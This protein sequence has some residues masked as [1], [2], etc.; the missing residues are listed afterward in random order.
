[1]HIVQKDLREQFHPANAQ[2][3]FPLVSDEQRNDD[4]IHAAG[5]TPGDS[6]DQTAVM[7]FNHFEN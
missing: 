3:P 4:G 7:F 6:F 5:K 1:M 2:G